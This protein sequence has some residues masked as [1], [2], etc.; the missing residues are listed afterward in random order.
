MAD[1]GSRAWS[2]SQSLWQTWANMS[3]S[4]SQKFSPTS[5][6]SPSYGDNFVRCS[7][8]RGFQD[9]IQQSLESVD[10]L[11]KVDGWSHSSSNTLVYFAMYLWKS[12]WN[13]GGDGNQYSTIPA[14]LS[15]I[16][17]CRRRYSD[18]GLIRSPQ[19]RL[20]LQGVNIYQIPLGRNHP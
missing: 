13:T 3:C 15:S 9:Q 14:Q 5:T 18:I 7:L 16:M 17:W 2:K 11:L 20:V 10:S 6:I 19:L 8:G 4:W 12:C 1:V